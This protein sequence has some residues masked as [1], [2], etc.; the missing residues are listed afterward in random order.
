MNCTISASFN[1]SSMLRK[2]LHRGAS[3]RQQSQTLV[4][5]IELMGEGVMALDNTKLDQDKEKLSVSFLDDCG[6]LATAKKD[7]DGKLLSLSVVDESGP[8][9]KEYSKT[10]N[11]NQVTYELTVGE[12][13]TR[14]SQSQSGVLFLE[15]L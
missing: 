9:A 5:R 10:V 14:V 8:V 6:H 4:D 3:Q 11:G 15:I 2:S 7:K 12:Q 1:N 13:T